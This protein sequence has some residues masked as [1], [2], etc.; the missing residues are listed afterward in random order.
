MNLHSIMPFLIILCVA[1][2]CLFASTS[3]DDTDD[4]D[5]LR[6]HQLELVDSDG[7]ACIRMGVTDDD[8]PEITFLDSDGTTRLTLSA[9]EDATE[10][11]LYDSAGRGRSV[12]AWREGSGNT[13]G[14]R[15]DD[16]TQTFGV[17]DRPIPT[18]SLGR[19]GDGPVLAMFARPNQAELRIAD[20]ATARPRVSLIHTQ[21][22]AGD[23][24][25]LAFADAA[26]DLTL[27]LASYQTEKKRQSHLHLGAEK[28][29]Q[30]YANQPADDDAGTQ[31]LIFSDR[32][33]E[34]RVAIT[35]ERNQSLIQLLYP[36]AVP[37]I[38]AR[39]MAAGEAELELQSEDENDQVRFET[40]E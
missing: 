25:A 22:E 16:E 5:I 10:M 23:Y 35:A 38:T 13:L 12:L 4:K 32:H 3:T 28:E 21:A 36:G 33:K 37:A 11:K 18:F 8:Q 30:L 2:A 9:K 7:N 17:F 39:A 14:F 19:P 34:S 40:D 31:G 29:A 1:V 6:V 27:T 15:D 24:S 20:T 26:H